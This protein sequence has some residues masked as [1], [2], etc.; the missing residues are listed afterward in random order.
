MLL[1][2][3]FS[4]E[5]FCSLRSFLSA[6]S[7]SWN[8]YHFPQ[9]TGSRA[10]TAVVDLSVT[11][12]RMRLM[13]SYLHMLFTRQGTIWLYN[14]SPLSE[15]TFVK[16]LDLENNKNLELITNL[17]VLKV[18]DERKPLLLPKPIDY[19]AEIY[20]WRPGI[21][22]NFHRLAPVNLARRF[23]LRYFSRK[24]YQ[25]RYNLNHYVRRESKM[26]LR[27]YQRR[28]GVSFDSIYKNIKYYR[29][30]GYL[31]R[32][33]TKPPEDVQKLEKIRQ[34]QKILSAEKKALKDH[35]RRVKRLGH[36]G[37]NRIRDG[38]TWIPEP[39][40]V[41]VL[42]ELVK[43]P[44]RRSANLADRLPSL[45]A[46][47]SAIRKAR[48]LDRRRKPYYSSISSL[49]QQRRRKHKSRRT[50]YLA[51]RSYTRY[52]KRVSH[53]DRITF[54]A[55]KLDRRV[56]ERS[57][58]RRFRRKNYRKIRLKRKKKRLLRRSLP[59]K[60][61]KAVVSTFKYRGDLNRLFQYCFRRLK[62]NR[63][64]TLLLPSELDRLNL[65]YKISM[66][67]A[68]LINHYDRGWLSLW[69]DQRRNTSP[70]ASR[71]Y[72]MFK[73]LRFLPKRQTPIVRKPIELPQGL[74]AELGAKSFRFVQE[75]K[76]KQL[77]LRFMKVFLNTAAVRVGCF[78]F[79]RFSSLREYARASLHRQQYRR[80]KN[81]ARSR[82]KRLLKWFCLATLQPLRL[83]KELKTGSTRGARRI[84]YNWVSYEERERMLSWRL[85]EL[86]EDAYRH[87]PRRKPSSKEDQLYKARNSVGLLNLFRRKYA[88][89][90]E[91]SYVVRSRVASLT[92][93]KGSRFY[94]KPKRILSREVPYRVSLKK[95][96]PLPSKVSYLP[97]LVNLYGLVSNARGS[98]KKVN[99]RERQRS[100]FLGKAAFSGVPHRFYNY[101][102]SLLARPTALKVRKSKRSLLKTIVDRNF[103]SFHFFTKAT[104]EFLEEKL[105]H[106]GLESNYQRIYPEQTRLVQTF[107][108]YVPAAVLVARLNR[109]ALSAIV[110]TKSVGIPLMYFLTS[111][112]NP[113]SAVYPVLINDT[114]FI[115]EQIKK[116]IDL[117]WRLSVMVGLHKQLG[118][119]F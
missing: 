14:I 77:W 9:L 85:L 47:R 109:L 4:I 53:L 7:R 61:E 51:R 32:W 111:S 115:M 23:S 114:I 117:Q 102:R 68:S 57:Q 110:E 25:T 106:S 75:L 11:V 96:Q 64:K 67:D 118:Y 71:R 6:S 101:S 56:R 84:K 2:K 50:L 41:K 72:R 103:N 10:S 58:F 78:K 70:R 63:N 105:Y 54:E 66:P 116:L 13:F 36:Y 52:L 92:R 29:V 69:F 30:K 22:S 35:L 20:D 98:L 49:P 88:F 80:K 86:A 1:F 15:N 8:S 33:F 16:S 99:Y 104:K 60:L 19:G 97:I 83:K 55:V 79:L 17:E 24:R 26:S 27:L 18:K 113:L 39:K 95:G 3:S 21:L 82:Y 42:T 89:K 62:L 94:I 108:P 44:P 45:V 59:K 74:T 48:M 12:L 119:L 37:D 5:S 38:T 100:S 91:A 93:P 90:D 112:I 46:Y 76:R 43:N 31:K 87:H 73:F 40:W 107:T 34:A 28:K 81:L 65:S